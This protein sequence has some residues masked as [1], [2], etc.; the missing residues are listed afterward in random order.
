MR[1][2]R[3]DPYL[4]VHLSGVAA[5]PIF[6]ELCLL[7]L[8]MGRSLMPVWFE[9]LFVGG[10]GIVPIFWMQWQKP[11]CIFSLLLLALRPDRMSEEQ[12]KL[13]GLFKSP[14]NQFLSVGVAVLMAGVLWRF[15]QVAP[16]ANGL[17]FPTATRGTGLLVA[18]IAFFLANLFLQVPAS[19]LRVLLVGESIFAAIEPYPVEQIPDAFTLTGWRV[20]K[21]LPALIPKHSKP[22]VIRPVAVSVPRSSQKIEKEI[23]QD[24]QDVVE[25]IAEIYEAIA[26]EIEAID[27]GIVEELST[28]EE[29]IAPVIAQ[30]KTLLNNEGFEEAT[31]AA[32]LEATVEA[33]AVEAGTILEEFEE[34]IA[35][36]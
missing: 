26:P 4:W 17:L 28:V 29:A 5:V 18:A 21:I 2:F 25:A 13:L 10:L 34:A 1:S 33:I 27:A 20:K 6:L 12:R 23:Q 3:S 15:Y 8:G 16:I 22:V 30:P 35:V 11:F 19:V 36:D 14:V 32:E 31:I 7:G 24:S 9:L